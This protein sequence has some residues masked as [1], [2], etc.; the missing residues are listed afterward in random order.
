MKGTASSGLRVGEPPS[1][2]AV[3]LSAGARHLHW[4]TSWGCAPAAADGERYTCQEVKD[5]RRP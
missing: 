3:Q 2:N 1:N 4:W 5:N